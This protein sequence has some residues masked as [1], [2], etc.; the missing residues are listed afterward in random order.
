[1]GVL[2]ESQWNNTV[3]VMDVCENK[4]QMHAQEEIVL[5]HPP[6]EI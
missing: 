1:M 6:P 4:L 3:G 2:Y 5:A